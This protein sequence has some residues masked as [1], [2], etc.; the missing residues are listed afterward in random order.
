[1]TVIQV[2]SFWMTSVWFENWYKLELCNFVKAVC[3]MNDSTILKEALWF[4]KI[5]AT[6]NKLTCLNEFW[7]NVKKCDVIV[8]I[9]S[10][11]SGCYPTPTTSEY[12][13]LQ[14]SC[15]RISMYVVWSRFW[16]ESKKKCCAFEG[17]Y[18]VLPMI[19]KD[20]WILTW[21]IYWLSGSIYTFRGV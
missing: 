11:T 16:N 5:F 10:W 6:L 3:S 15:L 18:L 21:R 8:F 14:V 1:M 7:Y 2:L 20:C 9:K 13:I 12:Y 17:R 19:I 4:T